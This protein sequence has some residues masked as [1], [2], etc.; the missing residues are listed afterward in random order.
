MWPFSP[1][2]AAMLHFLWHSR[3]WATDLLWPTIRAPTPVLLHQRRDHSPVSPPI[4]HLVSSLY[5]H[6]SMQSLYFD[7]GF[8]CYTPIYPFY[9]TPPL[10]S[11]SPLGPPVLLR[12]WTPLHGGVG[13]GHTRYP[14]W[15]TQ[16]V[17]FP[18]PF[19]P[20]AHK[21]A[22]KWHHLR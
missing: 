1:M 21:Y 20:R 18:W 10:R 14:T 5:A 8:L 12:F 3:S 4:S 9:M 7:E 6:L 2:A 19:G 11:W 17:Y 15:N 22:S 13:G 16:A